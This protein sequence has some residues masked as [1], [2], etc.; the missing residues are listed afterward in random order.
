MSLFDVGRLCLKIAGR[1]AG[2]KCV[3]VEKVDEHFVVI[4][5]DVRRK[6]VNIK[7]LEPLNKKIELKNKA[8]HAEV[9]SAFEKL[10]LA[11]WEKKS[12]K[13]TERPKKLKKKKERIVEEKP[14]RKADE[15]GKITLSDDNQLGEGS[16]EELV[17]TGKK[18]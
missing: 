15:T 11:V 14:I 10:G 8:S 16:V 9:K 3:V 17:T 12:K 18:G 6:K 5:G 7:H 2:R 1:D 13:A 4:D